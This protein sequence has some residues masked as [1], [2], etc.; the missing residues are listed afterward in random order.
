MGVQKL[1]FLKL[2]RQKGQDSDL[3]FLQVGKIQHE[4]VTI[5]AKLESLGQYSG[6]GFG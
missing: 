1:T 6:G 5:D 2:P 3:V 4:G